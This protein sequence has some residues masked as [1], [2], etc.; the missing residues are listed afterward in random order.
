MLPWK[1][2][3]FQDALPYDVYS[4]NERKTFEHAALELMILDPFL[5]FS[6]KGCIKKF[7]VEEFAD[8]QDSVFSGI[9]VFF[10]AWS[11]IVGSL[12]L[13]LICVVFQQLEADFW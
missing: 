1:P 6:K 4:N 8:I 3:H 9:V 12:D 13:M 2:K 10:C 5:S 7:D 11:S